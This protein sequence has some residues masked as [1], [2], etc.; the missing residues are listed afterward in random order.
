MLDKQQGRKAAKQLRDPE[1]E[2]QASR[3]LFPN[4]NDGFPIMAFKSATVRGGARAFGKT[5]VKMTELRQSLTFIPDGMSDQGVQLVTLDAS[6]PTMRQDMVRVGMGTSDLRYRP[7][8]TEWA[9]TLT[10]QY[11]RS[12]ISPASIVALVDAGGA[13]GVGDWRPERGGSF[14]TYKVAGE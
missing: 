1:A 14:G 2:F 8:Y 5:A 13:N 4:G 3:Y 9:A 7:E 11:Q 6:E 10:V 12:M